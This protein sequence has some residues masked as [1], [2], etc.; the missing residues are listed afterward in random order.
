MQEAAEKQKMKRKLLEEVRKK[1]YHFSDCLY[2]DALLDQ[3][4]VLRSGDGFFLAQDGN[5]SGAVE[6]IVKEFS[7]E[8]T[9]RQ[10]W[11]GL[12]LAHISETLTGENR[13]TEIL[14]CKELENGKVKRGRLTL[15]F[16]NDTGEGKLHHFLLVFETFSDSRT[17]ETQ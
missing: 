8:E 10:I 17:E 9:K 11:S 15:L 4:E 3:Y 7:T 2:C 5:Y 1:G 14:Y 12:Q 6:Q 16:G 13:K